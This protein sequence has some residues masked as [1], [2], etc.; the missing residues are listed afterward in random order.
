MGQHMGS[1][2]KG[3]FIDTMKSNPVH[4]TVNEQPEQPEQPEQ[5]EKQEDVSIITHNFIHE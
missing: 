4:L 3:E 1:F 5:E 2:W